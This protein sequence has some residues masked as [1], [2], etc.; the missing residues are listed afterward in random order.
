MVLPAIAQ[1]CNG[2]NPKGLELLKAKAEANG[3]ESKPLYRFRKVLKRCRSCD[4]LGDCI[5]DFLVHLGQLSV[6]EMIANRLDMRTYALGGVS[7]PS[8]LIENVFLVDLLSVEVTQ[9][10]GDSSGSARKVL[11]LLFYLIIP[12]V[13]PG[14]DR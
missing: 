1:V 4:F 12:Q 10:G 14:I 8:D 11:V 2:W 9:D 7:D 13:F 6:A 5:K 3:L